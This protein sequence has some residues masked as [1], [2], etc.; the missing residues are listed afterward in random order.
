MPKYW[1]KQ[2]FTHRRFSEVGQRQKTEREKERRGGEREVITMAS[3]AFAMPPR[4][5]HA[6]PP[7]PKWVPLMHNTTRL[8]VSLIPS[9]NCLS[10]ALLMS[11]ETV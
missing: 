1:G 3:Y 4:V 5:A 6:K 9:S 7:W 10:P 8:S 11:T 2:I